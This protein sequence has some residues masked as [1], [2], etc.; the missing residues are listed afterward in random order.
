MRKREGRKLNGGR[1]GENDSV[2]AA[3]IQLHQTWRLMSS[4]AKRTLEQVPQVSQ[5][6]RMTWRV[7]C[8]SGRLHPLRIHEM[9]PQKQQTSIFLPPIHRKSSLKFIQ[10][11][12]FHSGICCYCRALRS[13]LKAK[14]LRFRFFTGKL[15][16]KISLN[17]RRSILR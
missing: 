13:A 6:R 1:D 2:C 12:N 5:Q 17:Q 8:P 4:S 11:F 10:E 15:R 16:I 3:G 14:W 7:E 9:E